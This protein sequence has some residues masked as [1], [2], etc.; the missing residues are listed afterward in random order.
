MRCKIRAARG[1]VN[2][3]VSHRLTDLRGARNSLARRPGTGKETK[4]FD[5]GIVGFGAWSRRLVTSVQGKSD[6]VWLVAG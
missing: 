5:L 3:W 1:G 2:D 6:T 4:V